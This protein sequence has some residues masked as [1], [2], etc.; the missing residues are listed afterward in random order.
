MET[1]RAFHERTAAHW[2][3]LSE[4][5]HIPREWQDRG[6]GSASTPEL[7]AFEESVAII[8]Q[9]TLSLAETDGAGRNRAYR[10][11]RLRD[12]FFVLRG[13]R[14]RSPGP[15]RDH[16]AA[17]SP[18]LRSPFERAEDCLQPVCG[19]GFEKKPTKQTIDRLSDFC[20]NRAVEHDQQDGRGRVIQAAA[21]AFLDRWLR[22]PAPPPSSGSRCWARR[23]SNSTTCPMPGSGRFAPRPASASVTASCAGPPAIASGGSPT[24]PVPPSARRISRGAPTAFAP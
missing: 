24:D 21:R 20:G 2:R 18:P 15:R 6:I 3:S 7:C 19:I 23:P 14:A 22:R 1:V 17:S 9:A 11:C 4:R 13:P 8:A 5:R 16:G 12:A 10:F